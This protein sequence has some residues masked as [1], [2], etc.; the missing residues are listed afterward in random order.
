MKRIPKSTPV[1]VLPEM[2]K[3]KGKRG[4]AVFSWGP[5]LGLIAEKGWHRVDEDIALGTSTKLMRSAPVGLFVQ[6]TV[7]DSVMYVRADLKES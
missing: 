7:R 1:E 4:P 2:S 5:W 3:P 6:A